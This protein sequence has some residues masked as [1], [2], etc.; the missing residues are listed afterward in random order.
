M[1]KQ[2]IKELRSQIRRLKQEL[3]EL[4]IAYE[5]KSDSV[6]RHR[7]YI[8]H[9]FNWFVDFLAEGKTPNLAWMVKN[10]KDMLVRLK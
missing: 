3:Y 1:S 2:N 9:V 8:E 7:E 10:I 6:R 5:N 4:N